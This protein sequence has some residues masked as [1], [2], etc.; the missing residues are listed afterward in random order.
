MKRK[1][2]RFLN[3]LAPGVLVLIGSG[4]VYTSLFNEK[5]NTTIY[6]QIRNT[7]FYGAAFGF[8]LI[9]T[10]LL[11]IA[12]RS[13]RASKD[14]VINFQTAD[15]SVSINTK[16]IRDFIG[17]V[18]KEFPGIKSIETKL[19]KSKKGAVEISMNVKLFAGHKIPEL[20]QS[21][22]KRVRDSIHESLGL[23]KIQ[24][25]AIHVQEIVG[26]PPQNDPPKTPAPQAT[27][28]AEKPVEP[29]VST[30]S[31]ESSKPELTKEESWNQH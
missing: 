29:A 28:P 6:E 15:G 23:T 20:S 30:P 8:F 22:K 1:I 9:A 18:G 3:F 14:E 24:Q 26:T 5:I 12:A 19:G 2:I 25:I 21:L 4:L 27:P 17:R 11:R 16:T 10:V 7:P 13:G 31:N